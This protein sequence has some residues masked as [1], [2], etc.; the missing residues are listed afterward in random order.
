M[1]ETFFP[2]WCAIHTKHRRQQPNQR[3]QTLHFERLDIITLTEFCCPKCRANK[4]NLLFTNTIHINTHAFITCE[5][6]GHAAS[7][8][9]H[10]SYFEF[11]SNIHITHTHMENG[12]GAVA[13]ADIVLYLNTELFVQSAGRPMCCAALRCAVLCCAIDMMWCGVAWRDADVI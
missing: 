10:V 4:E 2:D 12:G 7:I 13:V 11:N 5:T 9:V 3:T 1:L 8:V 6:L